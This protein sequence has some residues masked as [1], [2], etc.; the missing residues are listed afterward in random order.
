MRFLFAYD[1][2][3]QAAGNAYLIPTTLTAITALTAPLQ[4]KIDLINLKLSGREK[5]VREKN[6]AADAVAGCV[7]D[8]WEVLR[9]RARR[10]NQPAE[11]L[12]FYQLPLSGESPRLYTP[13]EWI[14]MGRQVVVG[15]GQAV[16]AGWPAMANPSAAELNALVL[17]A[18]AEM[19]DVAMADREYDQAQEAVAAL[20]VQADDL[21]AEVMAQPVSAASCAPMAR[22]SP[23][24][25]ASR[26]TI[27]CPRRKRE[28]V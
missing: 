8:L 20:R 22:N 16:A 6:L 27:P 14:A 28:V 5:E 19:G 15:D 7:Q 9:R 25:P 24:Y 21:I 4:G 17:A 11:V 2:R 10:L 12:T 3:R 26:R 1:C 23:I 13:D 18:E